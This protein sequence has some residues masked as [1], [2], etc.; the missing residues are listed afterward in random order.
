[1][2]ATNE[3]QAVSKV[4]A[5]EHT[6]VSRQAVC[7][8]PQQ[9]LE[10]KVSQAARAGKGNATPG[11]PRR[12]TATEVGLGHLDRSIELAIPR[13]RSRSYSRASGAA[14]AQRV[15]PVALVQEAYVN[16]ASTR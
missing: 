13:L 10:A 6:D 16:G 4:R 11:E 12:A 2:S 1:M 14:P 5:D 9:L 15:G 8:L 3:I 7:W